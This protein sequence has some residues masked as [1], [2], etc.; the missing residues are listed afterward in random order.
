MNFRLTL[1]FIVTVCL[2]SFHYVKDVIFFAFCPLLFLR[3][4]QSSFVCSSLPNAT[5]LFTFIFK[6]YSLPLVYK[7]IY[8]VWFYLFVCYLDFT[9]LHKNALIFSNNLG[10]VQLS[11]FQLLVQAVVLYWLWHSIYILL[12]NLHIKAIY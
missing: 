1:I 7:V 5:W 6:L 12:L 2:F 9:K 4:D 11:F 10:N 8:D 3:R